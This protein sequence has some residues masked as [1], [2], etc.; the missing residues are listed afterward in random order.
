MLVHFIF[1]NRREQELKKLT[2]RFSAKTLTLP[3]SAVKD[4]FF[5]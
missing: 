1:F 5:F 4:L 3:F 2:Q